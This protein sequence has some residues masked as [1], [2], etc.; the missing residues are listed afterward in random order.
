MMTA[1]IVALAASGAT[2]LADGYLS[3]KVSDSRVPQIAVD[4]A[5]HTHHHPFIG[6]LPA[7]QGAMM[8]VEWEWPEASPDDPA[9][10]WSRQGVFTASDSR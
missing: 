2:I 9:S 4:M 8:D 1:T 7:R 10:E 3:R 5:A 6:P